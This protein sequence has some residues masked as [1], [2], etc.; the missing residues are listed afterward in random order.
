MP[1]DFSL[2]NFKTEMIEM[3]YLRYRIGKKLCMMLF[4]IPFAA[5]MADVRHH[6]LSGKLLVIVACS[7][8]RRNAVAVRSP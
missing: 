2:G 6:F 1:R 7:V 4:R 5:P 3:M 8:K